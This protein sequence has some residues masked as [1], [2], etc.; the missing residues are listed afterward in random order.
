MARTE[1]FAAGQPQPGLSTSDK[2][3]LDFAKQT[4]HGDPSREEAIIKTFGFGPTTFFQ[5]LNRVIDD[6]NALTHDAQTVRRYQRIREQ[7]R[8]MPQ[9]QSER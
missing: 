2:A 8:S 4:K 9:R 5:K 6:P 7:G 3:I 1:E